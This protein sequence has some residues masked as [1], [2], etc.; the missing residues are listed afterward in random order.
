M[1]KYYLCFLTIC[2]CLIGCTTTQDFQNQF[3]D[4]KERQQEF[5]VDLREFTVADFQNA[6]A[7][8]VARGDKAG[9]MCLPVLAQHIANANTQPSCNVEINGKSIAGAACIVEQLRLIVRPPGGQDDSLKIACAEYALQI[10]K[11]LVKFNAAI[12]SAIAS[13]GGTVPA[14]A[15]QAIF[16]LIKLFKSLDIGSH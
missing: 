8:A 15:P 16:K 1:R 7:L 3:S 5:I 11:D 14:Q 6:A 12:A 13:G 4:F 10:A 2:T 9:A